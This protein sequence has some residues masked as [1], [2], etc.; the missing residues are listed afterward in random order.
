VN[1]ILLNSHSAS[2]ART[3]WLANVSLRHLAGNVGL[4]ILFFAALVPGAVSYGNNVADAIW[5]AGAFLMGAFSLVRVPPRSVSLNEQSVM[6]TALM[7]VPPMLVGGGTPSAGML[8]NCAIAVEL[9]G[10]VVSQTAR[11]YMGRRFGLLPANRGIITS[12]PFRLVRHPNYLGWLVLSAGYLMAHP[13][14]AYALMIAFTLP[15]MMWRIALEEN[16]LLQDPTYRTYCGT[17]RY[18]LIPGVL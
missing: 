2:I 9:V 1:Q 18:R 11:L 12:G 8:A 4:A 3:G 14:V 6:A 13:A 5:I 10:I 17:T 15:F 16:L 7:I